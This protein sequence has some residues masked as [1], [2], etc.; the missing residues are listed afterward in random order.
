[1]SIAIVN[2]NWTPNKIDI[3]IICLKEFLC[4]LKR[5][6]RYIS[7]V[8]PMYYFRKGAINNSRL[9]RAT[10][11]F[12]RY[13]DDILD[14]DRNIDQD[15]YEY[16]ITLK[17]QIENDQFYFTDRISY[18]ACFITTG[19]RALEGCKESAT[20]NLISLINCILYDF[21]RA[22]KR[23]TLNAE[24]INKHL[25]VS[26][27]NSVNIALRISEANISSKEVSE[28]IQ[29]MSSFYTV[30]DL[31]ADI[32]KNL[33]NIPNEIL[34]QA[35]HEAT[36]HTSLND[37]FATETVKTWVKEEFKKGEENL[38]SFITKFKSI[39]DKRTRGVLKPIVTGLKYYRYFNKSKFQSI[40]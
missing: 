6:I 1:M 37:L 16:T 21:E 22:R 14:G 26:L 11:C 40:N 29:A 33:I 4:L 7:V 34:S 35:K 15:P 39:D 5:N 19:F 8:F 27:E 24:D 25:F 10:Y 36:E 31:H 2:N 13:I 3:E 30:R 18:L 32:S 23:I 12:V 38:L 9:L 17:E 20:N 28:L